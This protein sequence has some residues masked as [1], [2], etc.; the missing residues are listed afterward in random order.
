VE[1]SQ[2]GAGGLGIS[3]FYTKSELVVPLVVCYRYAPTI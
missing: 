3:T 1:K 2:G